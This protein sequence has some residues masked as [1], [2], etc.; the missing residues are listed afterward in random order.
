[1]HQN[2]LEATLVSLSEG[3]INKVTRA[4]AYFSMLA[5]IAEDHH[6]TRRWRA[7]LVAGSPPREGSFAA[8]VERAQAEGLDKAALSAFFAN[9]Y[10]SPVLTAHPDGSSATQYP[11]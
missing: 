2:E 7:H 4:F 8:A 1:M 3:Q 9:A 10:I 5:N 11:R 6:H